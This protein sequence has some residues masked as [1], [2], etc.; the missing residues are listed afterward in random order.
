MS[1][2]SITNPTINKISAVEY[3]AKVAAGVIT[4]AM[5]DEQV[6]INKDLTVAEQQ[7][8]L[9]IEEGAQVNTIESVTFN[10][11]A[12]TPD[13]NKAV[14]LSESD[15]TVPNW[16]KQAS[17][18]S[19]AYSEITDKPT[20]FSGSYNDLT[21]KPTIPSVAGLASES[22]VNNKVATLIN[23]APETLDTLGEIA[24]AVQ[25]NTGVVNTLNA[26]IANKA[27]KADLATVATSGS[28]S[29]LSD[30]PT[31]PTKVGDLTND[32]G[33]ITSYTESDPTVPTWAKQANK[34]SYAYS[35]ISGTPSLAAVAT[36][37]SYNDLT[38]KPTIP[39]VAGLA[40]ETYVNN[41]VSGKVNASALHAVATSGSYNDLTDKPTIGS[42]TLVIW[43]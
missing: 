24:T 27:N 14:T 29:D 20:L 19:Y 36:S 10:G 37:G 43:E 34:P 30:K 40:S 2:R 28:Y 4:E 18:P 26:A 41:A 21:D 39:S 5:I 25:S 33:Y 22:Y 8:V 1:T 6:W 23:S 16:A 12:A 17:K 35:E 9:G 32:R 7:K 31:I 38:N 11:V 3:N 42:T 13:A 15:P